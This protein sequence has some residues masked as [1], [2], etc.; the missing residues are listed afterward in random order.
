MSKRLIAVIG[1]GFAPT[2]GHIAPELIRLQAASDF[3]PQLF[4]PRYNAFPATQF[5]RAL[6]MIGNVDAGIQAAQAGAIGI[7]INTFGDYGLDELRA[8]VRVPV[9]GAGEA[10]M[11]IAATLG[12]RFA[13]VTIWPKT[14]QFIFDDRIDQCGMRPHCSEVISILDDN[15][16]PEPGGAMVPIEQMR[17]GQ[18]TIVN[19]IIESARGAIDRGAD[20]I[21]LGCTCMAPIAGELA[22]RLPV[23]VVEPM[24]AGYKFTETLVSLRISQSAIAFPSASA[25]RLGA[26]DALITG[27]SIKVD[28]SDCPACIIA[29]E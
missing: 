18:S 16:L 3:Q 22:Q 29:E 10:A 13:I 1:T 7:F 12:R 19:R 25:Q 15:E 28:T 4:E 14:M 5:D 23:P 2:G 20:T 26:F 9:V 27:A 11:A 21:L 8:A 6:S 17:A 24:T